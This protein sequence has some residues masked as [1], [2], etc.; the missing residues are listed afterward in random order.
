MKVLI[1]GAG[2]G[3]LSTALCLVHHGIEVA[4][5]ERAETLDDIGAGIQLPP[6]AMR[7]FTALG[8]D[9]ALAARA[10]RPMALEARM[11]R[12]G[13]QLFTLNLGDAAQPRWGAPYL[14]IHRAD[15]IDVLAAALRECTFIRWP[16]PDR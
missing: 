5:I 4:V 6:N 12:S 3:G 7:V 11:G 10:F 1:S 14:H 9:A 13:R 15:Y 8:L 16:Q 2:I